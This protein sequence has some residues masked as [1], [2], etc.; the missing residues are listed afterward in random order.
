MHTQCNTLQSQTLRKPF[1]FAS[2]NFLKKP[3]LNISHDGGI[4]GIMRF[5]MRCPCCQRKKLPTFPSL[6]CLLE[7]DS[8]GSQCLFPLS[9]VLKLP[10]FLNKRYLQDSV[11]KQNPTQK[12]VH[13]QKHFDFGLFAK[14]KQKVSVTPA[15]PAVRASLL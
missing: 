12:T 1:A 2:F 4:C 7:R 10:S 11:G 15:D 14:D 6:V 13:Q 5:Y 3:G 9:V 8:G